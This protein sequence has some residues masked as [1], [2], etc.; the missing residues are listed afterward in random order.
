MREST[1]SRCTT[2]L[3][4][5]RCPLS[6]SGLSCFLLPT[7]LCSRQRKVGAA[8]HRGNANRPLTM[9]GKAPKPEQGKANALRT[10]T[11]PPRR[12]KNKPKFQTCRRQ[13]PATASNTPSSSPT[14]TA[15]LISTEEYNRR[16]RSITSGRSLRTCPPCP[17][18]T[19]TTVTTEHPSET[20]TPT[21]V[22]KSGSINS[23]K[24]NKTGPASASE[25]RAARTFSASLSN[26]SRQRTSRAPCPNNTIPCAAITKAPNGDQP[27]STQPDQAPD[28]RA[29]A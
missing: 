17:K 8:P 24:A 16:H 4:K 23:R 1:D 7:F 15:H 22:G 2:T 14:A 6:I 20:R 19:G 18:N 25:P 9:Q 3:C 29:P 10:L 5:P 21:A 13:Y 27:T 11:M 12:Q 26:G 28:K